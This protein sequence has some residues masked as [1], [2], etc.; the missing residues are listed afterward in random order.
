MSTAEAEY[1][2]QSNAAKE[3][4]FLS[5]LLEELGYDEETLGVDV[6]TNLKFD[7]WV[8]Q[9]L[10]ARVQCNIVGKETLD[11]RKYSTVDPLLS[12]FNH[13]CL[14]SATPQFIGE[15]TETMVKAVRNIKE[16]E[17]ICLSYVDP[18]LLEEVRRGKISKRIGKPC[19]CLKRRTKGGPRGYSATINQR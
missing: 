5:Q 15:S 8:P 4:P 10:L 12:T 19:D 11:N 16:G 9:T 1:V 6:F 14:P 3:T 18:G 17:E 13:N 2:A 7:S